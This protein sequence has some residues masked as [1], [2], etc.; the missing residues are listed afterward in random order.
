MSHTTGN[1]HGNIELDLVELYKFE[2]YNSRDMKNMIIRL[3]F[4]EM[5]VDIIIQLYRL[6]R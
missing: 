3:L 2:I 5:R 6:K 4:Q 1:I